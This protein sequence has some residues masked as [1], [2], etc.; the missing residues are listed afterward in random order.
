LFER[1]EVGGKLHARLGV[2]AEFNRPRFLR[3]QADGNSRRET[4]PRP[5]VMTLWPGFKLALLER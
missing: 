3:D 5:L 1:A 4:P 2:K